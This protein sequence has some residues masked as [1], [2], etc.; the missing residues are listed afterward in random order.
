MQRV[1]VLWAG[2]TIA[3]ALF[4]CGCQAP[5]PEFVGKPLSEWNG[6][7]DSTDRH[8]RL[9]AVR[10][11]GEIARQHPDDSAAI[12]SLRAALKHSDGAVR[13]WAVRSV[14]ALGETAGDF[15]DD[16]RERLADEIT[17]VRIWA[18]YGLCRL[19]K[20]DE[21]LPVLADALAD[22][23]GG[24]RLHAAHAL[25]ALGEDARP[26]VE[27]LRGVLGDEFGYPDRVAGRFLKSLGEYP[28][29]AAQD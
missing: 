13:H 21:A 12:P 11:V 29:D 26:V 4:L 27:A 19:G 14:N 5:D 1:N 2:A 17:D 22:T 20:I 28:P 23:N 3:T 24:A 15:E 10:A 7:L 6:L 25:E 16:L 18:A 9:S 8:D